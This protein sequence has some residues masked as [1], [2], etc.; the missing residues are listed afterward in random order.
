MWKPPITANTLSMPEACIAART[1]LINPAKKARQNGFDLTATQGSK[2][3][4]AH[5]AGTGTL[6]TQLRLRPGWW[7]LEA[8]APKRVAIRFEPVRTASWDHRKLGGAY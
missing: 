3:L 2:T 7:M 1:V 8:Q 5:L 4:E 6:R